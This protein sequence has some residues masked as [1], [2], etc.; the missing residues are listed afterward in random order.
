MLLLAF[1]LAL[2]V[3]ALVP[4]SPE[5]T[6]GIFAGSLTNTPALAGVLET[7]KTYAPSASLN[8]LLAEPV[9]GYSVTYPMGVIGMLMAI[10]VLQRVFKVNYAEEAKQFK[11][12]NTLNVRLNN[13]TIRVT[14]AQSPDDYVSLGRDVEAQVLARAVH[15]HI[16]GRVFLN[17]HKT[18]VFPPSPG[19]YASERM[20]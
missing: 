13:R 10:A 14:H 15:A 17:G 6:A 16:H 11:D 8:Q 7:I 19:S 1:G 9:V 5:L 20:G 4:S 12:L 18:V 3:H 2:V